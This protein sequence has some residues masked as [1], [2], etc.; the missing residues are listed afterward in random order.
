MMKL[1]IKC[2]IAIFIFFSVISCEEEEPQTVVSEQ[3]EKPA[4]EGQEN[5]EQ[6]VLNWFNNLQ[7]QN[8]LVPSS[9]SSNVSLYDNALA[10]MVFMLYDKID[11]AEKI[12]DF[13]DGRIESEFHKDSGGFAQFRYANGNPIDKHQW[14]GDNAWLLIALNN[15]KNK[16]GNVKYNRLASELENWLRGLQNTEGGLYGGYDGNTLINLQVTEGMID[17]FNAVPGY[18]DFH[19]KILQFLEKERWNMDKNSL[20]TG[21]DQFNY[22]LDLHSWSYCAFEGFPSETLTE[23]DMFRVT[24]TAVASD[25]VIS[26]YCFDLDKDNI[27]F[28]GLGEMVVAFNEAEM[29][30]KATFYLGELEKAII[31]SSVYEDSWGIPYAS[32]GNSTRFGDGQLY[33]PEYTEPFVSSSAWYLFS[34]KKF[35]P[36]GVGKNKMIPEEDMFW[37]K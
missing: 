19:K 8:G 21:W 7:L 15:Y 18:S 26:G 1:I 12:F 4:I 22:A 25:N 10:A 34:I 13:F 29:V 23:A 20:T 31:K 5:T 36:F 28:E 37:K 30:E 24:K 17:A 9:V 3:T 33:Q 27:W 32:N 2:L 11:R 35:T 16:T 14:M 6:Q